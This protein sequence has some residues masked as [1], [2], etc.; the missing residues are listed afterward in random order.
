M[1]KKDPEGTKKYGWRDAIAF[2]K[3][4][5]N[6]FSAYEKT[7]LPGKANNVMATQRTSLEIDSYPPSAFR[8]LG[9]VIYDSLETN[10]LNQNLV[11]TRPLK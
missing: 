10:H 4:Q 6:N 8:G 5:T 2:S 9:D 11:K 7:K 3:P 1:L